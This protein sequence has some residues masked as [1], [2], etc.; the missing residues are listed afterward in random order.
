M[1]RVISCFFVIMFSFCLNILN[2]SAKDLTLMDVVNK[3]NSSSVYNKFKKEGASCRISATSSK[4][5]INC[6]LKSEGVY[7]THLDIVD[8]FALYHFDGNKNAD[9]TAEESLFDV[10]WLVQLADIAAVNSDLNIGNKGYDKLLFIFNAGSNYEKYG[11]KTSTFSY[12]YGSEKGYGISDFSVYLNDGSIEKNKVTNSDLNNNSNNIVNGNNTNNN[13]DNN[14]DDNV[15]NNNNNLNGN[16]SSNNNSNNS[17]GNNNNFNNNT[18]DSLNNNANNNNNEFSNNTGNDFNDNVENDNITY[19]RD[20]NYFNDIFFKDMTA[21]DKAIYA[22]IISSIGIGIFAFSKML[23]S[24]K[25]KKK[26]RVK[27]EK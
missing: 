24:S 10:L 19:N 25:N 15:N 5:D 16:N 8:G 14:I 13:I 21:F 7:N 3:L 4:L 26:R 18:D 23:L 2:V 1:K 6:D 22:T 17:S 20:E 11:L 12:N 9:S 27:Y